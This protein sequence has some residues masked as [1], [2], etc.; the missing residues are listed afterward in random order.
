MRSLVLAAL[1]AGSL[2]AP[3]LAQS[4]QLLHQVPIV[5]EFRPSV[6]HIKLDDRLVGGCSMVVF[7]SHNGDLNIHYNGDA[8]RGFTF[9]L[10]AGAQPQ[11]KGESSYFPVVGLIVRTV[12]G[13]DLYEPRD[14]LCS[15]K[16]PGLVSCLM[17]T[18]A[19]T[20][21]YAGASR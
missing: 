18:Q 5:D 1:A 21:V 14:G 11:V 19:G 3:A 7:T 10:P 16:S 20:K 17:H 12:E 4:A 13:V 9:A 6:C 2:S 8:G 15:F